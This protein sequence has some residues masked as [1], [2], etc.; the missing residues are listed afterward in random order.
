MS[1]GRCV[2]YNYVGTYISVLSVNAYKF[3]SHL[4]RQCK[5][6]CLGNPWLDSRCIMID[7]M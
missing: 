6:F 4:R 7:T 1:A 3:Y 5:G 2:T